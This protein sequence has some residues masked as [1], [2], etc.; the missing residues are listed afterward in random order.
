MGPPNV[1]NSSDLYNLFTNPDRFDEHDP[2]NMMQLPCSEYFSVNDINASLNSEAKKSLFLLHVN[3]RSLSKNLDTL[4]EHLVTMNR[5][6]DIIAITETRLNEQ[7]VSNIEIH[8]YDF[9]HND[10]PTRAGGTA[11]YAK[12]A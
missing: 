4:N 9:L 5:N 8:N 7:S 2:D 3:I 6:P 12:K 11:I 10:S 1:N